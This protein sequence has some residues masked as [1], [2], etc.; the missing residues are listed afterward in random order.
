VKPINLYVGQW[1]Y[2]DDAD[3][4]EDISVGVAYC[5]TKV[6]LT[7]VVIIDDAGDTHAINMNRVSL[8]VASKANP[9]GQRIT[10]P[11]GTFAAQYQHDP[12]ELQAVD[13]EDYETRKANASVTSAG[14]FK[15]GTRLIYEDGTPTLTSL[16]VKRCT[17]TSVW[18]EETYSTPFN[19]NE[20]IT[21][22]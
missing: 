19:P 21:E 6:K 18:F 9:H 10:S 14:L 15:I 13:E 11:Q 1:V 20:F 7:C 17:A 8:T 3:E 2:I 5:I 22:R 4:R 16:T 12:Y